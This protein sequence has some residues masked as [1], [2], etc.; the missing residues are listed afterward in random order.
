MLLIEGFAF[1]RVIIHTGDEIFL[2][3]TFLYRRSEDAQV[4]TQIIRGGSRI[5][6]E[7]PRLSERADYHKKGA[8]TCI[9]NTFIEQKG[10]VSPFEKGSSCLKRGSWH[11]SPPLGSAP[12]AVTTLYKQECWNGRGQGGML[13]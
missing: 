2:R 6:L 9:E 11:H 3:M 8:Y 4:R 12:E 5:P 10:R 13:G 1:A 7:G